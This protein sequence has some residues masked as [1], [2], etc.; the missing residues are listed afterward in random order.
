MGKVYGFSELQKY[1]GGEGSSVFRG[2]I[3]D[4]N[5]L[6]AATYE[7][8]NENQQVIEFLDLLKEERFRLFATVTTRSEL[9]D[10]HRR[11][12]LTERLESLLGNNSPVRI[13]KHA[14]ATISSQIA[15]MRVREGRGSDPI[16]VDREIKNIKKA[17][18]AGPH[19]GFKGWLAL[20]EAFLANQ[21][22]EI[23]NNLIELGVEYLSPNEENTKELFTKKPEWKNAVIL[24]EYSGLGFS[25]AL[26]LN[27][28]QSSHILF[29]ISLDFD[30]GYA[31]SSDTTLKDVF[32]P[33]S[34]KNELRSFHFPN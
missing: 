9:L 2:A 32:V 12:I 7:I 10:F 34:N 29:A 14:K 25:D 22:S 23:D 28:L 31:I 26:I 1:L 19:S 33:D 18:S 16:F 21:L 11:L 4:T 15:T 5:I 3:L 20:C 17:F 27:M 13:T 8:K 6:A 24:S 30:F